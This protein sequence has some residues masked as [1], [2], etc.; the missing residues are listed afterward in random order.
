MKLS[1]KIESVEESGTTKF[2]SI[3]QRLNAEG[4]EI[5]NF[6]IGEPD[7]E[8]PGE[9]I[10]ATKKALDERRT[11]YGPV[12]G[13]PDLR[14]ELAR[15]FDGYDAE[16]IIISNGSKQCLF[17]V[18]QALCDPSDEVIIPR[19]CW[20]SFPQQV[21]LAGGIPVLVNTKDHQ[22]DCDAIEKAVTQKTKAILINTPNNPTGAV[23][24]KKDLEKIAR[25]ASE[26]DLY[27]VSDEAYLFFVYDT[28]DSESLFA[29]EDIRDRLIVTGSF[30]KSYSMTGFRVGY[31]A[32]R[33]D[34]IRA[35]TKCQSHCTGNVCTFA[36]HGAL[37]ALS[38][39][40]DII[41]QWRADLERKRDMAYGYASE[42]F[43]CIRPQGAFYL[44]PDVSKHLNAPSRETSADLAVDILD[45][46]GVAVVPGEAF[47]M[48][49]HIRIS[50]A[51][52]EDILKKGFERIAEVL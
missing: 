52:P 39:G 32:A 28:L 8:T 34:I 22:L 30:S 14:S 46:T 36:Q 12:P 40:E 16:N 29:L 25:I 35:V 17:S 19:P 20:T 4:K 51:V 18:F 50:Y 49:N 42:L 9:I 37:A 43:D 38:L 26:H 10:A 31:A 13:L 5:I 48:A 44:F 21:K 6:A 45:N 41:A 7:Y 1:N 15:S 3:I 11:G 27:I 23:Y 47:E 33:K 24:P 2:S